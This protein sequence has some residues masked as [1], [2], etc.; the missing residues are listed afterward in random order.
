M[1]T[2]Y[3][4]MAATAMQVYTG[5]LSATAELGARALR[6]AAADVGEVASGAAAALRAPEAERGTKGEAALLA[7][8]EAQQRHL[9]A[10][11][12][13]GPFW[14]MA[15]LNRLAAAQPQPPGDR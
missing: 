3:V 11:R 15:V 10:L 8:F 6:A 12:G 5:C 7:A 2:D 14:S 9:H 1:T 4:R 13:A